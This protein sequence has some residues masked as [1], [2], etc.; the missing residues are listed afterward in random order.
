MATVA[1]QEFS[2]LFRTGIITLCAVWGEGKD[3]FPLLLYFLIL[4]S[5]L[6]L[7]F[8]DFLLQAAVVSGLLPSF[9]HGRTGLS[10]NYIKIKRSDENVGACFALRLVSS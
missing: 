3:E 1:N 2:R 6:P 8:F 9:M 10:L 7:Y 4:L 5:L